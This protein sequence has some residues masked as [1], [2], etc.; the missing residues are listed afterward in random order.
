M[1]R[2]R[3]WRF[4]GLAAVLLPLLLTGCGAPRER[5]E[6]VLESQGHVV[7][8]GPAWRISGATSP[9]LHKEIHHVSRP[10]VLE[11]PGVFRS[12]AFE[13]EPGA[14]LE[15]AFGIS[16]GF[17][18]R[19]RGQ[20]AAS[21]GDPRPV[22]FSIS[23]ENTDGSM[24]ES[25]LAETIDATP[26]RSRQWWSEHRIDLSPVA[27]ATGRLAFRIGNLPEGSGKKPKHP[28][29]PVWAESVI[30]GPGINKQGRLILLVSADT[31]RAD[32][33]GA[34]GNRRIITPN[35]D[36][37]SRRCR[38]YRHA[39][40]PSPWTLPSHASL[41][42]ATY[43]NVHRLETY[44]SAALSPDIETITERL[45][46]RGFHTA[47]FV[48]MGFITPFKGLHR[49]FQLFDYRGKG[50]R[51]IGDRVL[52]WIE[53]R[54]SADLMV[55]FHFY[56]IH[57]P[58][59]EMLPGL[60]FA[61]TAPPGHN[62]TLLNRNPPDDPAVT[63]FLRDRYENGV[64]WTDYQF[65]RFLARLRQAGRFEEALIVF[66]SDHGEEFGEHGRLG[67]QLGLYEESLA[68][69]LL[70]KLP[71]GEGAG[72]VDGRPAS[73]VDLMPTILA[74]RGIPV[75]TGSVGVD[76]FADTD[77]DEGDRFVFGETVLEGHGEAL[78]NG[79]LKL[80]RDPAGT[81][82]VVD[83]RRNPRERDDVQIPPN[84]EVS[85]AMKERL[86]T[87]HLWHRPGLNVWFGGLR[88]GSR[89]TVR[90]SGHGLEPGRIFAYWAEVTP[91]ENMDN[92]EEWVA[93]L[94]PGEAVCGLVLDIPRDQPPQVEIEVTC[95]EDGATRH[96]PLRLAGSNGRAGSS[97]TLTCPPDEARPNREDYDCLLG[98]K[99]PTGLVHYTARPAAAATAEEDRAI[100]ERL[101]ELGYLE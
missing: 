79:E 12:A 57:H 94:D 66:L 20:G 27:G 71:G 56:D 95:M 21:H 23:F 14:V 63:S 38:L 24:A 78:V 19:P 67:H 99:G 87:R 26:D 98:A 17:F 88:P 49:G 65:G 82:S 62:P 85:A 11:G 54:P 97:A 16:G 30:H 44:S 42:T 96:V 52:H 28:P 37:F 5:G 3:T 36:R 84:D 51:T 35:I 83:L 92:D 47:A 90:V 86:V 10:V 68:I 73:L 22:R 100:T 13:V 81:V 93:V 60:D 46:R 41:L 75:P 29:L 40:A 4:I 25:L 43:P 8:S 6:P 74:H 18:A 91:R 33:L 55:F 64:A 53:Q 72:T 39:Y 61:G 80:V 1:I 48:D 2:C 89:I 45:A 34:Y 70:I 32:A 15:T 58:Y 76:L 50:I 101:R 77:P 59:D 9:P 7:V 31:C 69:P